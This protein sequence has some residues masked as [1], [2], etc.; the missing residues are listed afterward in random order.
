VQS[1][2]NSNDATAGLTTQVQ[3]LT[4]NLANQRQPVILKIGERPLGKV[5]LE[6][7]KNTTTAGG[8]QVVFSG[9]A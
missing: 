2:A 7:L 6:L 4:S 5:V 8:Q 3:N 9:G 1:I